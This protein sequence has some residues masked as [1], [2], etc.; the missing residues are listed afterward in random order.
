ME[1]EKILILLTLFAVVFIFNSC[2]TTGDRVNMEEFKRQLEE[3][4]QAIPVTETAA[5][6]EAGGPTEAGR[7]V[8]AEAAAIGGA[9]P[10]ETQAAATPVPVKKVAAAVAAKKPAVKPASAEASASAIASADKSA[11]KPTRETAAEPAEAQVKAAAAVAAEKPAQGNNLKWILV[12]VFAVSFALFALIAFIMARKRQAAEED[13]GPL[14]A[15]IR[16]E[17]QPVVAPEKA[18]EEYKKVENPVVEAQVSSPKSQEE[19]PASQVLKEEDTAFK[20]QAKEVEQVEKEEPAS[21]DLPG[22]ASAKPE[23]TADKPAPQEPA[24]AE[25]TA[26]EPAQQEPA[27]ASASDKSAADK[28]ADKPA[29]EPA[30][31]KQEFTHPEDE[32]A[33]QAQVAAIQA[34]QTPAAQPQAEASASAPAS[35]DKPA[36][37]PAQPQ[38]KVGE[39][40][41][42]VTPTQFAAGSKGN[43]V[44]IYYKVGGDSPEYRTIRITVPQGWS[45]PSTL[46]AEEGY[47]MASLNGGRIISTATEEMSMIITV[48]GLPAETGEVAVV[49]GERR[50]GGPGVTAQAEPGQVIFKIETEGRGTTDLMEISDSPTVEIN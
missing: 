11:G 20:Q 18:V 3:G 41:A 15:S 5:V 14:R 23:S 9:A 4:G 21:V 48:Y 10:K 38:A 47:F 46:P 1:K 22:E 6:S 35:A 2:L 13:E 26:G 42:G 17:A 32:S 31:E 36:G 50:G 12:S 44:H 30:Q 37:M 25:A 34:S 7:P 19:P 16:P 39:G 43:A 8:T 28:P 40:M 24:S 45:K 49:F 29:D 27:A 33:R